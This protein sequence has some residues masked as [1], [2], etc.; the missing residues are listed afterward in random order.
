MKE[1]ILKYFD[2]SLGVITIPEFYTCYATKADR[3]HKL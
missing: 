3:L 1:K 2:L